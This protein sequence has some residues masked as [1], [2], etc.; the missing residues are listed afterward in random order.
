MLHRAMLR[1][2]GRPGS[3]SSTTASSAGPSRTPSNSAVGV[4]NVAIAP[5]SS[6]CSQIRECCRG[7]LRRCLR[8]PCVFAI[9][10][11]PRAATA[12]TVASAASPKPAAISWPSRA[13][14]AACLADT[15][16]DLRQFRNRFAP[17]PAPP[18]CASRASA[19]ARQDLRAACSIGARKPACSERLQPLLQA[20]ATLAVPPGCQH[21][22]R[23]RPSQA[24]SAGSGLG[25][26]CDCSCAST[27]SC[28]RQVTPALS[29]PTCAASSC[30]IRRSSRAEMKA[31]I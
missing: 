22:P 12:S 23:P 29:P 15:A 5:H 2:R 27:R 8:R 16:G 7:G 25:W 19:R 21:R 4:A 20:G 24:A 31:A 10:T 26:N 1:A 30:S 28:A 13:A 14:V 18:R 6:P 11:Q 9:T 3:W 17:A